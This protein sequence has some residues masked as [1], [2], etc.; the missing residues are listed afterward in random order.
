MKR[1]KV[2]DHEVKRCGSPRH[3]ALGEDQQVR[4]ASEL[5][6]GH[7]GTAEHATHS[8]S[9]H[10]VGTVRDLIA[11]EHDVPNPDS[12]PGI[13]IAHRTSTGCAGDSRPRPVGGKPRT[14]DLATL[15]QL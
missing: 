8:K 14:F 12:R 9:Q 3:G 4:A 1:G 13:H 6:N 15:G 5:E 7:L 11:L 2:I 10:E